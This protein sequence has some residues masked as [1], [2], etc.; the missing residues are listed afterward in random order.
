MAT[1]PGHAPIRLCHS[2][3]PPSSLHIGENGGRV[4]DLARAFNGP[5]LLDLTSRPGTTD[6]ADPSRVR[7]LIE[8]H[9]AIGGRS[10]ALARRGGL[11]AEAWALGRHRVWIVE[12]FLDQAAH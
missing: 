7:D 9:V 12:W 4:L 11:T 3:F 10:D 2:E 1:G 5:G 6:P 8:S